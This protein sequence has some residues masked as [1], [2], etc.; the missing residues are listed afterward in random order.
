MKPDVNF[1]LTDS[2]CAPITGISEQ[3]SQRKL[4]RIIGRVLN[5]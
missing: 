5:Y 3:V 2:I 1:T 4:K